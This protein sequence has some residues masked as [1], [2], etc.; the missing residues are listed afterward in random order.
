MPAEASTPDGPGGAS[1][2]GPSTSGE[3]TGAP[4]GDGGPGLAAWLE[5]RLERVPDELAGRV[6]DLVD[7]APGGP[8][9]ER[10]AAAA[11]DELERLAEGPQDRDAAVRLLAADAALT[12]AFEAA[13]ELDADVP[14]L[15]DATGLRGRIGALLGRRTP[16]GG[17]GSG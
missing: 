9:P 5:P 13:A 14:A 2:G 3:P 8:V 11:V 15:A 7:G 4:A 12:W 6:R 17:G 1:T 16:E 10:L